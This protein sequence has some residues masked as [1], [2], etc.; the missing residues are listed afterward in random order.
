MLDWYHF[1]LFHI[2]WVQLYTMQALWYP[3]KIA[4]VSNII[5]QDMMVLTQ[6]NNSGIQNFF[7]LEI[8]TKIVIFD[9]YYNFDIH[10]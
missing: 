6:T 9:Q 2:S 4:L 8:P 1:F 3:N 7:N 10:E 5:V